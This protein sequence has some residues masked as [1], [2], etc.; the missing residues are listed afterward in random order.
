MNKARLLTNLKQN[1]FYPIY[2]LVTDVNLLVRI[3]LFGGV[4]GGMYM[5]M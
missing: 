2:S 4:V 1:I 5:M 3:V